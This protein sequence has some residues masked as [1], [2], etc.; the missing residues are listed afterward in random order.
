MLANLQL[1][2]VPELCEGM[3]V[4]EIVKNR[5]FDKCRTLPIFNSISTPG[6]QCDIASGASCQNLFAVNILMPYFIFGR[7]LMLMFELI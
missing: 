7:S 6:I 1:L 3:P 5:D 4:Y 2:A